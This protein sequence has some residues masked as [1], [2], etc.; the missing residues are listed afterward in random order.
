MF[1]LSLMLTAAAWWAVR[2]Y[3]DALAE[4]RFEALAERVATSVSTRMDDYAQILQ[5]GVGLF[6]ASDGVTR[7]EWRRYVERLGVERRYPGIQGIGFAE[8]VLP[9]EREAEE[10]RIRQD[11][12]DFDITPPGMREVYY[13]IIFLE[14]FVGR[15]LRAFG[16]DM[17][18]EPVRRAAM[19]R[20]RDQDMPAMTGKV[21]LVQETF[22]DVQAGALLYLPV[23]D[24]D[25]DLSTVEGRRQAIRGFV[26]SPFRMTDLMRGILGNLMDEVQISLYDE[27]PHEETLLFSTSS[28]EAAY[29]REE[30]IELYGRIW[31]VRVA[32]TPALE[33]SIEEGYPELILAAGF[34]ISLLLTGL[35]QAAVA[36]RNRAADL[37][38]TNAA[39]V[40]ARR[41]AEAANA[42]KS[43]FLAAA[44]HDLRQPLQSLGIYL[45][46][47]NEVGLQGPAGKMAG[48]ALD[49]FATAQRM[50]NSIMDIAALESG[51]VEVR[52]EPVDVTRILAATAES[53]RPNVQGKGLRMVL[54][55]C[56][57]AVV[58]TDRLMF[59]RIILNL[60]DNAVKYTSRGGILVSCRKRAEGILRVKVLDS[61]TGIARDQQA[62]IFEDFYQIENPERDRSKGLGLG[63]ATVARLSRL[64][65]CRLEVHSR[66]NWGTVFILELPLAPETTG[67]KEESA[68]LRQE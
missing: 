5:G 34:I 10:E 67:Q 30:V 49:S 11:F 24:S 38:E 37:A 25:A 21:T 51:Q 16:Y 27:T 52:A 45:S 23:Y 12:P 40:Q 66:K 20:A 57:G 28:G 35:T 60:L 42:S 14:P 18:S 36:V 68:P 31:V 58:R 7:Q 9:E 62:L 22:Q 44:S 13:P 55:L 6:D 53:M 63:L 59:E 50:L 8:R 19:E 61:G 39:L 17:F 65:G 56:E 2:S 46:L 1:L 47:L 29:R 64:L 41:Q 48:N 33:R 54:R 15:N 32:S 43:R 26:Y 4:A 3:S